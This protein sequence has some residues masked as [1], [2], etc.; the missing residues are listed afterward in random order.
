MC[1]LIGFVLCE[2][3][4]LFVVF[5][6]YDSF[7]SYVSCS[8]FRCGVWFVLR[9]LVALLVLRVVL[10]LVSLLVSFV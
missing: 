3:F 4:V 1:V 10:A 2:L 6:S 9:D 8:C 7:D 5:A